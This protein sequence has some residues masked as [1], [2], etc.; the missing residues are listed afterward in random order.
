MTLEE[1]IKGAAKLSDEDRAAL[2]IKLGA[3]RREQVDEERQSHAKKLKAFATAVRRAG[4]H[5]VL[6]KTCKVTK[7]VS[8]PV[9]L[10]WEYGSRLFELEGP[11]DITINP[12]VCGVMDDLLQKLFKVQVREERKRV[13]RAF[14]KVK[15]LARQYGVEDLNYDEAVE[16]LWED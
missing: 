1:I 11:E 10:F 6:Q 15:E 4:I 7:Q 14:K 2:E 12:H 9:E 3:W 8:L 16:F 5:K 13:Y